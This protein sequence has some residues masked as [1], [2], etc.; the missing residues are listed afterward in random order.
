MLVVDDLRVAFP[1]RDGGWV[2]AVRGVS[3]VLG[4]ELHLIAR[5]GGPGVSLVRRSRVALPGHRRGIWLG[6][7]T[8]RSGDHG[9]DRT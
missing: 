9:T 1:S 8:N 3:F 4:G 6:Q 2:E 7:V 5:R